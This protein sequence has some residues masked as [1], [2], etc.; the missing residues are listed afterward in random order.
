[1]SSAYFL[2]LE[3]KHGSDRWISALR[4]RDGSIVSSPP[5]LCTSLSSFYSDL[6]SASSVDP[7]V[8]ADLQ[9]NLSSSLSGS[10][11]FL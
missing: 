2:R 4:D 9:E 8:Q 6:F 11:S 1:M 7:H 5:D 10:Q 3:R